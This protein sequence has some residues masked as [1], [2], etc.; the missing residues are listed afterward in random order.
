[1]RILVTGHGGMLGSELMK[2]SNADTEMTSGTSL[3]ICSTYQISTVLSK[4]RPHAVINCAGIV[5]GRPEPARRFIEVN[6]LAPHLLA[7]ACDRYNAKLIQVSTDCV[8]SGR[9]PDYYNEL[10]TPDATDLYGKTKSLGEI[11][12]PPHLTVRCSFIGFGQWGFLRWLLNSKG[13]VNGYSNHHWN[14][15]T[16]SY[17]AK[18]I[19]AL[20]L[21]DR[22]GVVHR[23]SADSTTKYGLA[24]MC[25]EAFKLPVQVVL[26]VD[27]SSEVNPRGI[28]KRRLSSIHIPPVTVP[29]AEQIRELAENYHG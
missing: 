24:K 29:L 19:L 16:S 17:A 14:G 9:A 6:A 26:Y 11:I 2:L 20:A 7:E 4:L 21:S 28:L 18:E 15:L 27:E 10:S 8:F 13:V 3:D 12:Y 25:V 23:Y 5:K 1:M 22:T